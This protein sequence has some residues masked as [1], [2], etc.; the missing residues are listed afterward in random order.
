MDPKA[1]GTG[2]SNVNQRE[3]EPD[4]ESIQQAPYPRSP[5]AGEAKKER[6]GESIMKSDDPTTAAL[7]YV[8][9]RSILDTIL[10]ST[11]RLFASNVHAFEF[12]SGPKQ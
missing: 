8:Y 11:I 2:K 6:P 12:L 4:A 10:K 7:R 9:P 3:I 1:V 5:N